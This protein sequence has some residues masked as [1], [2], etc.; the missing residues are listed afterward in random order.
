MRRIPRPSPSLRRRNDQ[1][2]PTNSLLADAFFFFS[3]HRGVSIM[4]ST[5][6]RPALWC[7]GLLLAWATAAAV[8]LTGIGCSGTCTLPLQ[9][10]DSDMESD[11]VLPAGAQI[12]EEVRDRTGINWG[13][14]NGEK[15]EHLAII[16][17]LG[18][19]VGL[20]DFDGDGLLDLF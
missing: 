9:E 20:F 5:R 10:D 1:G 12:F 19:G 15:K 8:T 17:S 16:E 13:Y 6:R 7:L 2:N 3:S 4:N 11:F 14:Q 18:G